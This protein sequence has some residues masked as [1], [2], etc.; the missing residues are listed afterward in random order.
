MVSINLETNLESSF[1]VSMTYDMSSIDK[2]DGIAY[3]AIV[4][5]GLYILIIFEV[6]HFLQYLHS[7]ENK[8]N[9]QKLILEEITWKFNLYTVNVRTI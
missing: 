2:H 4:L 8:R 1:A 5:L 9:H 6:R 3:A 7:F